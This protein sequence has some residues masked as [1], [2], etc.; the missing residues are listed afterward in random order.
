MYNFICSN[1]YQERRQNK[2][3]RKKADQYQGPWAKFEIDDTN[4]DIMSGFTEEAFIEVSANEESNI[5][6]QQE[7]EAEKLESIQKIEEENLKKRRKVEE[8]V[9]TGEPRSEFHLTE[10]RDYQ[11]RSFVTPPSDLKPISSYRETRCFL[12]KH[13]VHTYSGHTKGVTCIEFFP[14]YGHLLLSTGM[15]GIAKIWDVNSHRKC[16]RSYKGHTKAIRMG[17]FRE[18][19]LTFAT[20]SYDKLVRLWDTETGK[21]LATFEHNATPYVVRINP[22]ESRHTEL[23]IGCSNKKVYAWDSR[24]NKVMQKY[25]RHLGAINTITF[26][27]NNRRFVTS[28]DDKTLRVWEYGIPVEVKYV[29]DP[30]MHSMPYVAAHPNGKW[31][32]AQSLDNN[33]LVYETSKGFR[34]HKSKKFSGHMIAGYAIQCGFSNDARYVLSGDS[35]GNVNFWDWKSMEKVKVMK[36]HDNVCIGATWHP[37]ESSRVVTCGWDGTI[38]MFE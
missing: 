37:T 22:T 36:A 26:I 15:D 33:I 18:D 28:S 1:S 24:T 23:L 30:S 29:A 38:K 3:K 25:D 17:S 31:L 5:L 21:V 8:E 27:D 2:L 9:H 16:V 13:W 19:G 35:E 32:L 12:P 10:E 4:E 14:K 20:A 7:L 34:Q 6:E 11:G